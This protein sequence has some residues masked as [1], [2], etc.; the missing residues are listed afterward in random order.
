MSKKTVSI[1]AATGTAGV[2]CVNEFINQELF[3]VN[4][5]ARKPGQQ[6]RSSSGM[7][8]VGGNWNKTFLPEF[9]GTP[10]DELFRDRVEPFV[11]A[12]R[13]GLIASG[14]LPPDSAKT[15][16]PPMLGGA[17]DARNQIL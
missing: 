13:A 2:A 17:I 8:L 11:A 1:F 9:K 3:D 16:Y 5:L 4:V 6:E 14:E 12:M 7:S 10:L 15:G